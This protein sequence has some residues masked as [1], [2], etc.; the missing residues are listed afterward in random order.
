MKRGTIARRI[1]VSV[2]AA[3]AI[4]AGLA[5]CGSGPATA[6]RSSPAA[7]RTAAA[8][9]ASRTYPDHVA[10]AA[11]CRTYSADVSSGDTYDIGT[12]LQQAEGSVSPKL[13]QDIQAV[14]NGGTL[15]HDMQAQVK[16]A[17]DCAL[18]KVGVSPGS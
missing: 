7:P 9:A 18:V 5:A 1:T 2:A 8:A 14:V 15:Q 16:V 10:D 4:G 17:I 3:A 6:A 12:A 13:A 11:L